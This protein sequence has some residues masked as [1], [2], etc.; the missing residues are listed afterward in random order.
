MKTLLDCLNNIGYIIL[1]INCIV[2][3]KNYRIKLKPYKLVLLYLLSTLIIQYYSAYLSSFKANNLFLS[4]YYFIEQFILLSLF[5]RS[6][7]KNMLLK[8]LISILLVLIVLSFI[9]YYYYNTSYYYKFNIVEIITTNIPLIFYSFYF[10]IES[11]N[12]TNKKFIYIN[13]GFFI[14]LFCSTLLFSC[15]IIDAIKEVKIWLWLFNNILY[16]LL[17]ILIFIEWYKNFRNPSKV[18]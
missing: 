9:I 1:A 16:I 12:N 10:I 5:Y 8:K 6:V 3:L 2:Y 17:Q 18:N 7:L 11:L 13:S 4:H 14:Y 15:G